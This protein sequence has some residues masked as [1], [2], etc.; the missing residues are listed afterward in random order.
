MTGLDCIDVLIA[1]GANL[2]EH[3]LRRSGKIA[4]AQLARRQG[5][6]FALP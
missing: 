3:P 6:I 4:P 2:V 1:P 5:A